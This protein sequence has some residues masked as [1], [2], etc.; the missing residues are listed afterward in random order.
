MGLEGGPLTWRGVLA[1]LLAIGAADSAPEGAGAGSLGTAASAGAATPAATVDAGATEGT[2][3]EDS[4]GGSGGQN[5]SARDVALALLDD[6]TPEGP[7][8]EVRV[9]GI[10]AVG[11]VD[12]IPVF[13][14]LASAR[15]PSSSRVCLLDVRLLGES[16][17]DAA[18]EAS[19]TAAPRAEPPRRRLCLRS[20]SARVRVNGAPVGDKWH[21]L[22]EGDAL[23]LGHVLGH[24]DGANPLARTVYAVTAC[25]DAKRRER[26]MAVAFA[27]DRLAEYNI[28]LPMDAVRRAGICELLGPRPW[29]LTVPA[30]E[31]LKALAEKAQEGDDPEEP[32]AESAGWG[33][34]GGEEEGAAPHGPRAEPCARR[35]ERALE[36]LFSVGPV[37]RAVVE[38]SRRQF[39]EWAKDEAGAHGVSF[40]TL[41]RVGLAISKCYE[42]SGFQVPMAT[43]WADEGLV[44][45]MALLKHETLHSGEMEAAYRRLQHHVSNAFKAEGEAMDEQQVNLI[46]RQL[47]EELDEERAVDINE[48]LEVLVE[49]V[50]SDFGATKVRS[51]IR[52]SAEW[53]RYHND[54]QERITIL[55]RCPDFAGELKAF[56]RSLREIRGQHWSIEILNHALMLALAKEDVQAIRSAIAELRAVGS[57]NVETFQ[58]VLKQ[59]R[60]CADWPA[61]AGSELLQSPGPGHP[62]TLLYQ[63]LLATAGSEELADGEVGGQEEV[64]R[65]GA[66]AEAEEAPAEEEAA[67][68]G[69]PAQSEEANLAADGA[70]SV[71]AAAGPPSADVP[72][73][74]WREWHWLVAMCRE[75]SAKPQKKEVFKNLQRQVMKSLGI[76]DNSHVC[77]K[78]E[79]LQVFSDCQPLLGFLRQEDSQRAM[80]SWE[81]ASLRLVPCQGKHVSGGPRGPWPVA[82]LRE[83]LARSTGRQRCGSSSSRGAGLRKRRRRSPAGDRGSGRR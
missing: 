7:P 82:P 54:L 31:E 47:V 55:S 34:P 10:V 43:Y 75:L 65:S 69:A 18:P 44:R 8:G 5:S 19:K 24:A 42:D 30:R 20:L 16:T 72:A 15:G 56:M 83:A 49:R 37:A 41:D 2:E 76:K 1:E 61:I 11:F 59:A 53:E 6:A 25:G 78:W 71:A 13:E 66:E 28:E 26:A 4:A 29:A 32:K 40:E 81:L 51:Y 45:C 62:S 39:V 35:A 23:A 50:W 79:H 77:I 73:G 9:K 70:A 52:G 67:A 58:V 57:V 38:S 74:E 27:R 3:A 33:C 64:W 80:R 60:D 68:A 46:A 12:G 14:D 21:P 48:E 36:I 63:A 22:A 17:P